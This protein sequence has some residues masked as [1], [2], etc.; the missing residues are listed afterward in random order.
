MIRLNVKQL[1]Q[2]RGKTRYWLCRQTGIGYQTLDNMVRHRPEYI[3]IENIGL[4]C[5]ALGCTPNDLF[6]WEEE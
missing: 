6:V 1:L 5:H 3:R 4:M 2:E